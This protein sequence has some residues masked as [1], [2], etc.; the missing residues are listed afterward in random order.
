MVDNKTIQLFGSSNSKNIRW[1][2]L[3]YIQLN[4]EQIYVGRVGV[5]MP[6]KLQD[7]LILTDIHGNEIIINEP[8]LK[9]EKLKLIDYLSDHA[10]AKWRPRFT[11]LKSKW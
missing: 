11:E 8:Q 2:E 1:D 7:K 5:M 6:R 9:G 10:P 4:E 3:D